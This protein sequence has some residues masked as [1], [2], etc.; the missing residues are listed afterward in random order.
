MI[1]WIK[2]HRKLTDWEWY[3]DNNCTRVFLHLL[4]TVNRSASRY[5]G[6]EVPAGAR[7]MGYPSLADE[8]GLSVQQVRTV[9]SKL[10]ST[11]EITVKATPKFSIV[12]I[13]NWEEHQADNRQDNSPATA[14]QQASNRQATGEQQH[15][16]KGRR[17][18][19]ENSSRAS[20]PKAVKGSR[21]PKDWTP[22]EK[23]ISDAQAQNLTTDEVRHEAD[24][25]RDYWISTPGAK[26]IKSD[27]DATWR[28][29]CRKASERKPN[30]PNRS[31]G[32]QSMADAIAELRDDIERS[33]R[34]DG[35]FSE[36][37]S[38]NDGAT[39]IELTPTGR[40]NGYGQAPRQQ[41]SYGDDFGPDW[42][43]PG[44]GFR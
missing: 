44:Q 12:S 29:W 1:G 39:I 35:P 9:F 7:V 40:G 13:A 4:L 30:R 34:G 25:F 23:N 11:G 24:K 8:C 19:G 18:E 36:E 38:R 17:K 41:N 20:T 37:P 31:A 2:L 27:W 10:K 42:V 5:A 16:K 32:G 15:L 3:H 43:L 14:E 28:N 21:L 22:S 26:G 6:Q 33:E